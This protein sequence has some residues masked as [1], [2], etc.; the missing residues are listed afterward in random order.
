MSNEYFQPGSVPASNAPGSSAVIRSEFT[1]V[2][3][4]FDKLPVMAGHANEIVAIN[5]TGTGLVNSGII[6]A[7]FVTLAGAQTITNKTIAWA[8]NTFPGFGTGAT[9]NAGTGAGEVLLL[10]TNNQLPALDGSLLTGI[11]TG[12]IT[13]V[14]DIE[15]G[16]TGASD[17]GGAQT[18]LGI[19]L[20]ADANNAVLTGAP[21]APTPATG[22][23]SARIATTYFVT[24]TVAAIGTFA[25][26][27]ANPLMNGVA[28]SG[29]GGLGSRDDHVHPTDT[30]RAPIASPAFTG[31]PTAPTPTPGDND[32]SIATTAFVNAEIAA[33][34]PYSDTNP[35]INGVAA[36][37][38]SARVSRQDH[39]HP[40]DTTRAPLASP[41]F[42]GDPKAPTPLTSDN[43][44]S[45]A[46][47]AFV[48]SLVA[49]QPFGMLPSNNV[50]LMNG[51]AAAGLG[52]T[53]S[54]DD[55]VHPTD[56]SRAPIASPAF[57]GN[58]TAP[59]PT[60][61]DNDT[62]I[63][64]TAFVN[65]EIAADRPYSDTN[66]LINGVA[67]QGVSARVSRQDH[68]HPTDTTRLP[69]TGGSITANSASAALTVTQTGA[70]NAF[71]V[72]DVASDTTPFIIDANGKVVIGAAASTPYPI[73]STTLGSA[74]KLEIQGSGTEASLP[75]A[76]FNSPTGTVGPTVALARSRGA[77]GAQAIVVD[78]DVLGRI[79]FIGSDGQAVA[80]GTGWIRAACIEAKVDG[81][82][83]AGSVPAR[84]SFSTTPSGSNVPA[85]RMQIDSAGLVTINGSLAISKT[86]VTA[87]AASDG[88]VFSGTYTPTL[89]NTTNVALSTA[90]V[91]QYMRVGNVV[92]VSGFLLI[93]P[94]AAGN[95]I[96]GMSLPIASNFATQVEAG[97]TF[98]CHSGVSEGGGILA[99]ATNNRVTL[100][101]MATSLI[102]NTYSYSFTYLVI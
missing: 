38:V 66:P 48:Q 20:K 34:R 28:A 33:D 43:D 64:T 78:D 11:T 67:A 16:G 77:V 54:R 52:V 62:S 57:T 99:D 1:S 60:P 72:E 5:G 102:P 84:L 50:P 26:S 13:G 35:L 61:G 71:V 22:D 39:V 82:P 14:V 56:T 44:T 29:V 25:P 51:V 3:A 31:N 98:Y 93:D 85:E 91:S 15:H 88:N 36:Q 80:V 19:D 23:N 86:A 2:G 101:F 41:T 7:D 100:N 10:D 69:V 27:N 46:T 9:K 45:I 30:S 55:H 4:A 94:T 76:S 40:T 63:A 47:T 49:Q 42:T 58:P 32:T 70:G 8:S 92:T 90:Q 24:E 12:I 59:T 18:A 74:H 97:G 21:T 73:S 6:L 83:S 79:N 81:I 65:A 95:T 68:V 87:P 17:L 53:G 89:T 75:I 37:G 96:L